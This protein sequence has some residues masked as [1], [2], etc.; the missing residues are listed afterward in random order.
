MKIGWNTGK[1]RWSRWSPWE[2]YETTD[3]GRDNAEKIR[4]PGLWLITTEMCVMKAQR[5]LR[6]VGENGSA[7]MGD[8]GRHHERPKMEMWNAQQRRD[9]DP[10]S[11]MHFLLECSARELV[12]NRAPHRLG[13]AFALRLGLCVAEGRMFSLS[14]DSEHAVSQSNIQ[15]HLGSLWDG[16]KCLDCLRGVRYGQYCAQLTWCNCALQQ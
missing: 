5:G 9:V 1:E 13:C 14:Y 12:R 11:R 4:I 3:D 10:P 6:L 16:G 15:A 7:C 8:K 2:E